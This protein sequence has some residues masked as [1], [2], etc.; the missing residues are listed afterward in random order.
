MHIAVF[1]VCIVGIFT[2]ATWVG[3]LRSPSPSQAGCAGRSRRRRRRAARIV[4]SVS[5]PPDGTPSSRRAS[6]WSWSLTMLWRSAGNATSTTDEN[7]SEQRNRAVLR[8]IALGSETPRSQIRKVVEIGVG[9][10]HRRRGLATRSAR[11]PERQRRDAAA[12]D[13][14]RRWSFPGETCA[15]RLAS[16]VP[17][18]HQRRRQPRARPGWARWVWRRVPAAGVPAAGVWWPAGARSA[19]GRSSPSHVA[20]PV[21]AP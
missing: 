8:T 16:A 13:T 7:M 12:G 19:P 5:Q 1:A 4:I 2:I 20:D 10:P 14:M 18:R 3:S 9:A 15:W 21:L 6:A 17:A 11:G